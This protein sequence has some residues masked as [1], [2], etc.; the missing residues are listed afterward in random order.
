MGDH[1][2]RARG[3][4]HVW[5]AQVGAL[6]EEVAGLRAR[7]ERGHQFVLAHEQRVMLGG[8]LRQLRP[9]PGVVEFGEDQLDKAMGAIQYEA[10]LDRRQFVELVQVYLNACQ[11]F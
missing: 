8:L 11:H 4:E 7:L 2:E 10:I 5:R 1:L 6:R 3:R 9:I